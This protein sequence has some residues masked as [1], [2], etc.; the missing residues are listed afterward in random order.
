M[1]L[2]RYV[3]EVDRQLVAAA[4]ASGP[5]TRAVVERL[6]ATLEPA[7]RLALLDALG[8]ATAEI[9]SELAPGSVE[10]RLRGRE[11]EFVVSVPE[12]VGPPVEAE[13]LGD[14]RAATSVP[15][16]PLDSGDT[17]VARI[18][19]RLPT[20]LKA[21]IEDAATADGVSINAWLV[22]AAATAVERGAARR[23]DDQPVGRGT[24]RY[25]G[26]VR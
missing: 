19:L 26:W 18:N 4:E 2:R 8:D 24:K 17:E 1:E 13:P 20:H 21:R 22:R 12:P 6:L 15:V 11:P 7:L 16:E 5:D 3:D 14:G 10:V 9:T 25:T 23:V